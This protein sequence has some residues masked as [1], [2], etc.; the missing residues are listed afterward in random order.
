M[1][2]ITRNDRPLTEVELFIN[3]F[4]SCYAITE[5]ETELLRATFHAG[6]CWHFAHMLKDTFDR[7]TVVWAAPFGHMCWQDVDGTVYDIEGEYDGEA[8]YFIPETFVE[9]IDPRISLDFK[10]IPN[11]E[12]NTTVETIIRI[13]KEY[14]E[15]EHIQY[16]EN[17]ENYLR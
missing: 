11:K 12:N 3:D 2:W 5:E 13:M 15:K 14:C 6:Y 4:M 1:Q 16:D 9:E 8:F 7:G 17:V 10:H